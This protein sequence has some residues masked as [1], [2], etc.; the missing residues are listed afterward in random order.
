MRVVENE[1]E[2]VNQNAIVCEEICEKGLDAVRRN[3]NTDKD[4]T[5]SD[6]VYCHCTDVQVLIKI[7]MEVKLLVKV[8]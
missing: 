6:F 8:L 4:N 5:F 3:L 2:R 7:C 1:Q